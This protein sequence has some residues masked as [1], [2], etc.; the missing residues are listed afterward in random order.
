MKTHM[1][2]T[3]LAWAVDTNYTDIDGKLYHGFIGL[4]RVHFSAASPL[5]PCAIFAT[6]R[7]AK[8][9][10]SKAC[11]DW[12]KSKTKPRVVRVEIKVVST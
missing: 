8:V 6:R 11:S 10:A 4:G 2:N 9:A 7:E 5:I 3:K 12:C 1:I